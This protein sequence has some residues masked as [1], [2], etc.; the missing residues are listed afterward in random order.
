MDYEKLSEFI[1]S[2]VRPTV[3]WGLTGVAGYLAVRGQ[4]DVEIL[5]AL[6]GPIVGFWFA[7][8]RKP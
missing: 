3:T 1:R 2:L 7:D 5:V 6:V 8:R 4:L